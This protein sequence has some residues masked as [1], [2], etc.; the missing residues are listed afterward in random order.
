LAA[1]T[2]LDKEPSMHPQNHNEKTD[3]A[4]KKPTPA[5]QA[6]S[7]MNVAMN[8]CIKDC[9][10]CGK[11]CQEA[12]A[13]CLQKGGEYAAAE[14]ITLLQDCAAIC[15]TCV[16]FMLRGSAFHHKTCAIC[17]DV[18]ERCAKVCER[19]AGD[20]TMQACAAACR[21]CAASCGGMQ[22]P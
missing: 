10:D 12:I 8:Q 11:I 1:A 14:H 19:M 6:G 2:S 5:T 3:A 15:Q 16:G 17:A 7:K 9:Q 4:T 20:A 22:A 21:R 13:Y 18:C